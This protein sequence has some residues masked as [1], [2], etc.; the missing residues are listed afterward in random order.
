M[1]LYKIITAVLFLILCFFIYLCL[2]DISAFYFLPQLCLWSFIFISSFF[3]EKISQSTSSNEKHVIRATIF[4]VLIAVLWVIFLIYLK[5]SDLPTGNDPYSA[6][7][8][9]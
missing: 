3:Y 4:S 5:R 1:N 2:S 8:F 6:N 9:I 7:R